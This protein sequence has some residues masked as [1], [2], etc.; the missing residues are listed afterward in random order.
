[1]FRAEALLHRLRDS[2]TR[3]IVTDAELV[4]HIAPLRD[5]LPD[6]RHV[7]LAGKPLDEL[8]GSASE[9]LSCVETAADDPAMLIYTSGTTG[10]PRGALHAHR[11]LP[12]R[13]SGFELIHRLEEGPHRDR[14]FWTPADWAWVGGLVVCVLTP[15]V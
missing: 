6:L 1:L 7:I 14:P 10:L 5:E 8:I 11:F 9:P 15:W 2:G 13:L 4:S 3:L 12:G